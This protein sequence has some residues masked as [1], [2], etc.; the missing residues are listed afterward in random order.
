[1]ARRVVIMLDPD[2]DLEGEHPDVIVL[3][4]RETQLFLPLVKSVI[5]WRKENDVAQKLQ[6]MLWSGEEE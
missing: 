3:T 1:M 4:H 5:D 6:A 2:T